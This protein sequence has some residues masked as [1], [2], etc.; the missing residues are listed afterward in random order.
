MKRFSRQVFGLV[1][2]ADTSGDKPIHAI[3][4]LLV[5]LRKAGGITLGCLDQKPLIGKFFNRLQ[6][7]LLHAFH[8]V[9]PLQQAECYARRLI[10]LLSPSWTENSHEAWDNRPSTLKCSGK[11]TD[12]IYRR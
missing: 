12:Q 5:Q 3:K 9:N 7:G 1:A 4:V 8:L 10:N 11:S 6:L 2:V